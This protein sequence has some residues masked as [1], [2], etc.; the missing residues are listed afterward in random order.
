[1]VTLYSRQYTGRA[2]VHHY[3][4]ELKF[5]EYSKHK[6]IIFT[7]RFRNGI[8][9]PRTTACPMFLRGY[10]S[11]RILAHVFQG[12]FVRPWT[13]TCP[14][15]LRGYSSVN[16]YLPPVFERV[17]VRRTNSWPMFLR[18]YSSVD[19]SLPHKPNTKPSNANTYSYSYSCGVCR[20][21]R[22]AQDAA[23]NLSPPRL[24]IHL[25]SSRPSFTFTSLA[26][27][28]AGWPRV[29]SISRSKAYRRVSC[30]SSVCR[31]FST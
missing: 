10:S 21:G 15:Y 19:E 3:N 1:M 25:I 6:C 31:Q 23:G 8:T 30:F 24:R 5:V 20:F 9:R 22:R 16:E 28:E 7:P 26:R 29:A 12:V 11:R 17:F 4:L 27:H 18:R 14:M 2:L 13:N